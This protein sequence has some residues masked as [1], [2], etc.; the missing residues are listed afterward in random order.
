[1]SFQWRFN[2]AP[3]S[4]AANPSAITPTLTIMGVTL[5]QD[6]SYDVV[7]SD[8]IGAVVSGPARLTVLLSPLI[9][10]RPTDQFVVPGGSFTAGVVIKGNPPPFGYWWRQGS[11]T[12]TAVT[13]NATNAFF[14]R[15]NLQP[16]QG[17]LYRVLI[18]NAASPALTINATFNVTVL[19]DA[20]GDGLA[21]DWETAYFGLATSADRNADSDGDGS[22]NW[23]EYLAGTDP[24]D[25]QSYMKIQSLSANGRASLSF[26]T[27][28][29]RTYTL[30]FT[31][32]LGAGVWT[33]LAD[34]PARPT[35][36]VE[37]IPDAAYATNRCYRLV[38]PR[39]P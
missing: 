4:A 25:A 38:T 33:K 39:Q 27:I 29:N 12:L 20:D 9:T 36:G 7:I 19:G 31:D 15:T 14:T 37:V 10:I 30:Q 26:S 8:A 2:G 16:G 17:G 34:V 1:M 24:V 32:A 21:D 6:G 28:S 5:A 23:Q 35:N 13:Q 3:I 11:T 18:T 22:L